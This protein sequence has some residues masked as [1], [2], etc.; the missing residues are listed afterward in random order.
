MY[1]FGSI[2]LAAA[3]YVGWIVVWQLLIAANIAVAPS[4]PWFVVGGLG[5]CWWLT[6]YISQRGGMPEAQPTTNGSVITL[7]LLSVLLCIFTFALQAAITSLPPI[8]PFAA[9]AGVPP[10]FSAAFSILGPAFAG[11][12]E[13]VAFR[14]VIQRSLMPRFRSWRAIG[15]TTFLFVLWHFWTPVFSYQ[16][17]G[18]LVLAGALGWLLV[19]SR[20]VTLCVLAHGMV[21]LLMNAYLFV[22][23]S[24]PVHYSQTWWLA[25]GVGVLA[26]LGGVAFVS[27]ALSRQRQ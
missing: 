23:G 16:W 22:A 25:S 21:N 5:F 9:P 14:G 13:E 18:Y 7:M 6:R 1:F 12:V 2:A 24:T 10:L 4:L 15:M 11:M 20:S 17:A 8:P 26:S 27:H 3:I 19:V